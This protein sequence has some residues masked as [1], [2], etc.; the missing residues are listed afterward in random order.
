MHFISSTAV[1]ETLARH[2]IAS[3]TGYRA[4][5]IGRIVHIGDEADNSRQKAFVF[6]TVNDVTRHEDYAKARLSD[7]YDLSI[8]REAC[9]L[10]DG[11]VLIYGPE[12]TVGG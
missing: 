1:T 2:R 5:T 10:E 8:L 12:V 6:E 9:D 7:N 11:P 4:D 3:E